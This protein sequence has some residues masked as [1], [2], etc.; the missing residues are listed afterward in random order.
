MKLTQ[1]DIRKCVSFH[2]MSRGLLYSFLRNLESAPP[3]SAV[4][5]RTGHLMSNILSG[6]FSWA[7]S[8]EGY[9][10]WLKEKYELDRLEFIIVSGAVEMPEINATSFNYLKPDELRHILLTAVRQEYK[11]KDCIENLLKLFEAWL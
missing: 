3:I 8:N 2:L 9:D 4:N 5:P 6:C 1:K 7:N 10:F 11:T